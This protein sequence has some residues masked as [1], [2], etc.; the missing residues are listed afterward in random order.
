LIRQLKRIVAV[1]L[2]TE[3]QTWVLS[4]NYQKG[5]NIPDG[6]TEFQFM[7]GDLNFDSSSYDWLVVSGGTKSMFKGTGTTNGAG[8]YGFMLHSDWGTVTKTSTTPDIFQ[9]KIGIRSVQ[10]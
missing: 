9:I 10:R 4:P 1:P 5:A 6:N 8:N 3:K 7:A 2:M